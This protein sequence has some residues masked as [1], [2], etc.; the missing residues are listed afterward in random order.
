MRH[1]TLNRV[2]P[3]TPPPKIMLCARRWRPG[4][5]SAKCSV[6]RLCTQPRGAEA[7]QEPRR[8]AGRRR[9]RRQGTARHGVSDHR[10]NAAATVGM[11]AERRV[12]GTGEGY[13]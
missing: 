13:R 4:A 10:R 5:H 3:T 8:P 2:L 6:R 7:L 9:K 11:A 12:P 1:K